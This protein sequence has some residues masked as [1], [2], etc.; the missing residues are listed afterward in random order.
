MYLKYFKMNGYSP[1]DTS[2]S[3]SQCPKIELW[4]KARNKFLMYTVGSSI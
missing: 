2:I 3:K 1:E 4:R